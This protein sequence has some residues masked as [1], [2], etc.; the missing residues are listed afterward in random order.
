MVDFVFFSQNLGAGIAE[1]SL[2]AEQKF[3][4]NIKTYCQKFLGVSSAFIAVKTSYAKRQ[5]LGS[6][7]SKSDS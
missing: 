7:G 4:G 3:F 6:L 2:E 5:V 1:N